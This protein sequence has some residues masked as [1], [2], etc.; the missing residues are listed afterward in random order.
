MIKTTEPISFHS[1]QSIAEM[2]DVSVKTV[3]RWINRGELPA[4]KLGNQWRVSRGDL[5]IFL[6]LRRK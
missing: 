4:H 1:I 5:E 3:R 2:L 6:K